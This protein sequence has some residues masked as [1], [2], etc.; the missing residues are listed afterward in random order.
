MRVQTASWDDDIAIVDLRSIGAQRDADDWLVSSWKA[1]QSRATEWSEHNVRLGSDGKIDLQLSANHQGAVRPYL[2]A[3][4]QSETASETGIWSWTVQAPE[5]QPGAVFGMFLFQADYQNDPWLEFDFE[6]VGADTTKVQLSIHM[7]DEHG[8][9]VSLGDGPAGPI[10][11]DLGFDASK[12]FHTYQIELTGSSAL[13]HVDG[14]VVGA[15]DASDMPRQVWSSGPV[16]SFT[17]IW[18]A[19]PEQSDWA[20]QIDELSQPLTATIAHLAVPGVGAAEQSGGGQADHLV[21][22]DQNDVLMGLAG[23]DALDG[24]AGDDHLMGNRGRDVL[25][26]GAGQDRLDGG[27]GR[28]KLHGG[29]GEDLL[30]GGHGFDHLWGGDAGDVFVIQS[31]KADR[32]RDFNLSHGDRLD[33]SYFQLSDVT[34]K[35]DMPLRWLDGVRGNGTR[36][37]LQLETDRGWKTLAVIDDPNDQLHL[38]DLWSADLL[39]F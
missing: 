32:I 28:D 35:A 26:G 1:G 13:F 14:A 37:V 31:D 10:E 22:L 34:A 9:R 39:V 3:E 18:A 20:G 5:M 29:A 2:G 21:G 7:E 24:A 38:S 36:D 4:I 15:F 12:G 30:I 19:S 27:A 17:D 23:A 16:K 33:L 6:F 25:R 8:N 11:I